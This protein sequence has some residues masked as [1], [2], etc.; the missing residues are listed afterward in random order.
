MRMY[1]CGHACMCACGHVY[2]EAKANLG[3][4]PSD[5][6]YALLETG[7]FSDL[8]LAMQARQAGRPPRLSD[9]LV[10]TFS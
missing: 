3:Y 2:V 4:C 6:L 9:L 8:E 1:V 5:I 10:F 7:F